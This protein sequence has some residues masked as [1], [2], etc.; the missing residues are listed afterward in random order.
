MLSGK[1]SKLS[2]YWAILTPSLSII[3]VAPI[4]FK[5]YTLTFFVRGPSMLKML[6]WQVS[7]LTG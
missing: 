3:L 7:P 4:V 1:T 6:V 5:L 2:E